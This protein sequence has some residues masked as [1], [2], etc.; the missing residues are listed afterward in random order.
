MA[1]LMWTSVWW[2]LMAELVFTLVLVIPV[3]RR[4]RNLIARKIKRLSLGDRIKTP[5]RFI[6]LAFG[7][8]LV[9]SIYTLYRIE[10]RLHE[11]RDLDLSFKK[12]RKMVEN[13]RER[14]CRAQRNTYLAG[15]AFTLMFV[16]VRIVQLL[17]E[18][19]ELE[20]DYKRVWAMAEKK[21]E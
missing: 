20:D 12:D 10:E 16:I 18:N 19:I 13:L 2:F 3:P 6:A 1:S 7:F 15:F 17:K 11:A 9:E 4:I 21:K 8:A 5:A 14:K